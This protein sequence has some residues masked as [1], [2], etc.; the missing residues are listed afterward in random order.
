MIGLPS[1]NNYRDKYIIG[2]SALAK[3][4]YPCTESKS[5]QCFN[6]GDDF[7]ACSQAVRE[8]QSRSLGLDAAPEL[9]HSVQ[10]SFR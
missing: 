10:C 9:Q 4:R 8:S 2:R 6:V 3:L 7:E 1:C 5:I